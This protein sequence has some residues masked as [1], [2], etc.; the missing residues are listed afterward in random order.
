MP[1]SIAFIAHDTQKADMVALAQKYHVTL[2][3]YNS[4]AT[5]NTGKE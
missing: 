3:R 2:S 4:L 1:I 5:A